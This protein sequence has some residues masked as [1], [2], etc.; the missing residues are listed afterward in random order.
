MSKTRVE[1]QIGLERDK[2]RRSEEEIRKEVDKW[3]NKGVIGRKSKAIIDETI[4]HE[5]LGALA[6]GY[7][8][9]P[10]VV[11]RVEG[12][13]LFDPDGREYIDLTCGF[14]VSG[15]GHSH[16]KVVKA[17]TKQISD[18]KIM[19]YCEL[20]SEVRAKLS[21]KLIKITPGSFDKKLFYT[22][23]G[24][25]AVELAM[26][27][28]R[29]YTGKPIILNPYQ[30]YHGRTQ[31]AQSLTNF[32]IFWAY[33]NPVLPPGGV[34]RFYFPYCY[35][36]PFDKEF[37][38]CDYYCLKD[39]RNLLENRGVS[40]RVPGSNYTNVAAIL[41]ETFQG[42]A[43]LLIP[44]DGYLKRL[45]DLCD[46]YG[47]LLILDEIQSGMGRSGKMWACDHEG[48]EPDIMLMSKQLGGGLPFSVTVGR[49][50]IMD[51]W[52]P[53]AHTTTFSGYP[54]GCAAALAVLE[55]M[56]EENL[57]QRA[58]DTGEYFLKELK[59]LQKNHSL[60][61]DVSGR[62]CFMG[63]EFVKDRETREPAP[64]K[65]KQLHT[66]CLEEGLLQEL[67]GPYSNRI[68]II[69]QFTI[70]KSLV[71]KVISVYDKILSEIE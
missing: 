20:P 41:M 46:E 53:G 70:P 9:F 8:D 25:E 23:T 37:P 5:S 16:P 66:R 35:R 51:S 65:T 54:L 19:Q 55:V 2:L 63:I 27:L 56:E 61:G 36:C 3:V 12:S 21:E 29:W 24:G 40:Y 39:L 14:A 1:E 52:G 45:R 42:S 60:I 69:P 44:P 6:F 30:S 10:L 64:E 26:K 48:V 68:P 28:A 13:K 58:K 57:V 32:A 50:E 15:M 17:I 18:S 11:D 67:S 59:S 4:K 38:D 43:G 62:G 31:G 22:V 33:Q 49:R 7:F 34:E 71:D 47:I